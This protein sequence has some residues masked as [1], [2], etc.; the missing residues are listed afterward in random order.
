MLHK[1][2]FIL[3]HQAQYSRFYS[4]YK[5]VVNNQWKSYED[6]KVQQEKQLR[7]MIKF[8]YGNVPYYHRLFKELKISPDNIQ[9][10]EDLEKLPILT[11][12]VIK[13]NWNEFIPSNL[14][15]L[16]YYNRTTGGS[17]GNPLEYRLSKADRFLSAS[18]LYRG[19]G[20]SGYELGNK[21]VFLA[22]TSLDVGSNTVFVKKKFMKLQET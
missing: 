10:I 9:N 4:T 18:L 14:F 12:D 5:N 21:M 3:A 19:W 16:R 11:K 15:S 13:S 17:T 22:G 7:Q 2:L 6:Q 1:P 8:A 20:Y